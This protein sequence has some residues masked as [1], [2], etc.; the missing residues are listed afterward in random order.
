MKTRKYD[1]FKCNV[2]LQCPRPLFNLTFVVNTAIFHY[3]VLS[4]LYVNMLNNHDD[5]LNPLIP[6]K[7][8]VVRITRNFKD[9]FLKDF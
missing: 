3:S 1:N 4:N 9:S 2:F 7:P 6:K 5:L 8:P